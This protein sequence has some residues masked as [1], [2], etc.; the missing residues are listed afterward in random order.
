[1]T[2]FTSKRKYIL[3]LILR[4]AIAERDELFAPE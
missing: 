1:M 3:E 4:I 2:S